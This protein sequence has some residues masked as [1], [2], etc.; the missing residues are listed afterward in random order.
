[1]NRCIAVAASI[2]TLVSVI[3]CDPAPSSSLTASTAATS[4]G[5][6]QPGPSP[7][8]PTATVAVTAS[9][10]PPATSWVPADPMRVAR[11]EHTATRLQDGRVL[12]AGGRAGRSSLD[13]VEIFDPTTES[14]ADA[15]A[16]AIARSDHTAILLADGRVLV[17][18]GQSVDGGVVSRAE[19]F[20]PGT[21][22][23]SRAGTSIGLIYGSGSGVALPDGSAIFHAT[24]TTG[25]FDVTSI[26]ERFDP[27]D[28][29]WTRIA[30]LPADRIRP[31]MAIMADGGIL[32]AGGS[33]D[34][35]EVP[36]PMGD[37]W[38]LDPATDTLH[39]VSDMPDPGFEEPALLLPDDRLLVGGWVRSNVFDP[40]SESWTRTSRSAHHRD[41]Q[42]AALL[43]DGRVVLAGS[44]SC[45]ND[46]D[47]TEIYDPGLNS[48]SDA[49]SIHPY[50][51]LAMTTLVDGRVLLAG[52]GLPCDDNNDGNFGPFADAFI[53]DPAAL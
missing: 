29:T 50:S 24:I 43:A 12:V 39:A 25:P 8:A 51:D 6:T 1:M 4:P 26:L 28:R 44:S 40:G 10:E 31:S 15:A 23:W 30:R 7:T 49:G 36:S 52:G 19:I 14:W 20:D 34:H 3:A 2:V 37:A 18:G 5:S 32:I 9:P 42:V 48:W 22:E 47:L 27:D 17:A 21:G 33:S 16:L 53:L 38:V 35:S 46:A 11:H 41:G 45:H 13:T